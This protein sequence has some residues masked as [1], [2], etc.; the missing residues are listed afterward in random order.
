MSNRK[1]I[2]N[3]RRIDLVREARAGLIPASDDVAD[4]RRVRTN[5]TARIIRTAKTYLG[6]ATHVS[7]DLAITNILAD[8]RHYCD[9]KDLAFKKLDRAA[10]TLHLEDVE[11]FA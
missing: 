1:Q 4:E 6:S 8:L 11:E 3:A 7:D 2:S 10:H 9:C 5:H